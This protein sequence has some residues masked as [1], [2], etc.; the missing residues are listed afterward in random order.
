MA[1]GGREVH[2][3]RDGGRE[4]SPLTDAAPL[5]T[6]AFLYREAICICPD[7]AVLYQNRALCMKRVGQFDAVAQDAEK[8][9]MLDKE[10]MKAGRR[11][12]L[13]PQGVRCALT[14]APY[15]MQNGQPFAARMPVGALPSGQCAAQHGGGFAQRGQA[16]AQGKCLRLSP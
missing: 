7:L 2:V 9:L 1:G 6:T 15:P 11:V 10:S 8:A 12:V 13:P 3:S 14:L 16:L 4:R 5:N